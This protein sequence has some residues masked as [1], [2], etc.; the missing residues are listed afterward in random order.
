MRGGVELPGVAETNCVIRFRYGLH[1]RRGKM[2]K[3]TNPE[4]NK[5]KSISGLV[6]SGC[7][8]QVQGELIRNLELL[9]MGRIIRNGI[10][11]SVGPL[12]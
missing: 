12:K 1:P 9:V 8:C 4:T 2:L 3:F 5:T 11:S 6:I 10:F 7:K